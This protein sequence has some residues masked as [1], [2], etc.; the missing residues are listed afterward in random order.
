MYRTATKLMAAVEV[1]N[2]RYLNGVNDD[3]QVVKMIGVDRKTKG[4][5]FWPLFD[6]YEVVTDRDKLT[7]LVKK[8]GYWSKKV[9]EF[10]EVLKLKGGFDYMNQL[11]NE[12]KP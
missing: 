1:V 12:V 3:D 6:T 10:N 2:R 7:R 4:F 9:Q 5:S 11:N 8:F